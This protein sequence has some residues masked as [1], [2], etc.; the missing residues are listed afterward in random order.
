M[1]HQ[2]FVKG[3]L[4]GLPW[5]DFVTDVSPSEMPM[6]LQRLDAVL[7]P[8]DAAFGETGSYSAL[9]AMST[10]LP[11]IARD[12][13]GIRYNCGEVPLY[14]TEDIDL[15]D[16]LRELDDSV[17]RLEAGTRARN[18]VI[19]RHAVSRHAAAHSAAFSEALSCEVSI[20]MPV[21]DTPPAYLADCW[22]SIRSQT[23]RRWELVL[24]DDGSRS[25]ETINE[26]DRIANDPRVVLVR[27]PTNQ[28]IAAALNVGL[29]SCRANLVARMDSDDLM[30]PTRLERQF[31]Y[32][33]SH[34][35]VTIVGTQMQAIEWQTDR[36]LAPRM[37]PEEVTNDFIQNQL[38]TSE[39]W[40]INHPTVML[41]RDAVINLGGYPK[42]RVAQ[43]LGLWLRVI[44]A[45]LVIHNLPTVELH[46][47]LHPDQVTTARGVRLEEYAAIVAE[48]WTH[49][50][51]METAT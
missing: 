27:L 50:A 13:A 10:G 14:A 12:V 11:V 17:A 1:A 25:T 41:R 6:T 42:Y 31:D 15:L 39:I 9:E 16:R 29:N 48:C 32:L 19:G 30:I 23:F 33:Q 3:E 21:F 28:G 44:K 43:D 24:V 35:D 20:L 38:N 40:F 4:A 7:V 22:E 34:A 46:Y 18:S 51:A 26:I 47:R 45:G 2:Q 5:I 49:Q 8:T 36:L 37:H